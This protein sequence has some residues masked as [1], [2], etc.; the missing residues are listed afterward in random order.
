MFATAQIASGEVVVIWGGCYADAEGAEQAR[1]RGK[2]VMH[3]DVDL[4]SVET[5][6]EDPSYFMNHSCDPNVWMKD[7]TALVSRRAISPGEELTA[8]YA[9]WEGE[10]FV[11]A[12]EC[13]CGSVLCRHKITGQDWKIQGL[14]EKYKGHFSPLIN[15]FIA[16]STFHSATH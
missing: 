4:Y 1:Q 14:Q 11:S 15:K 12:W 8:D 3:L 6:G 16:Q 9:L 10:D 7:A 13:H 2:L 5:R